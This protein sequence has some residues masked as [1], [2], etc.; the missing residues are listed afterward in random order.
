[1][2]IQQ[3]VHQVEI[4]I[5]R[6]VHHEEIS[7]QRL[8]HQV[9]MSIQRLLHQIEISIQ[10]LIHQVKISIQRLV[11]QV[12]ISIQRLVHQVEISH[13]LET[14]RFSQGGIFPKLYIILHETVKGRTVSLRQ[15]FLIVFYRVLKLYFDNKSFK[16]IFIYYWCGF[17]MHS[18]K[19]DIFSYRQFKPMNYPNFYVECKQICFLSFNQRMRSRLASLVFILHFSL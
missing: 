17:Y 16:A 7:I 4:S 14:L 2:S 3:L 12:G 19:F 13:L 18:K 9:E 11:H 5:Q 10:R 8:V 6:L 15:L 1:M